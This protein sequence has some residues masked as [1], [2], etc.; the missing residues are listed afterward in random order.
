[1]SLL[2]QRQISS[3][4]A[5]NC[6]LGRDEVWSIATY[7]DVLFDYFVHTFEELSLYDIKPMKLNLT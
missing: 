7:M 3:G 4:E 5:L 6:S 1:M 2:S